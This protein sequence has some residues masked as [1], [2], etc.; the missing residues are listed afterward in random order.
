MHPNGQLPAYEWA[1]GDVNPPVH[2]AAARALYL[3]EQ[4]RTGQGDHDFL[5]RIFHKLLLNFTWWVNRKD[6]AGRN[7]FQGG[8]LG[9]DNISVIDRSM[10]LPPG[11]SLEQA[12]G[13]AWMATYS[14]TWPGPHS[15]SL[16][17]IPRMRTSGSNSCSTTSRSAEP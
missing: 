9:L 13:T 5:A 12:D 1:F 10:E 15:S 17:G 8:F 6:L 11:I 2:I 7:I 14:L 4:R 3:A 16:R